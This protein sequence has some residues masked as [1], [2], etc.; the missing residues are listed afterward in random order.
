MSW[1]SMSTPKAIIPKL[2]FTFVMDWMPTPEAT[3]RNV[4]SFLTSRDLMMLDFIFASSRPAFLAPEEMEE[5]SFFIEDD[6]SEYYNEY[7]Q[8]EDD[9]DDFFNSEYDNPLHK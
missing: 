1:F 9:L 4:L 2:V 3:V 5:P 8:A 7:I 6:T